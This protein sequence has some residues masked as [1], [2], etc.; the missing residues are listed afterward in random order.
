MNA[1]AQSAEG[2]SWDTLFLT[3]GLSRK[4]GGP[5]LSVSGLAK[6]VMETGQT[7]VAVVGAYRNAGDWSLDRQH[8]EPLC[9][10]ALPR[11]GIGTAGSVAA[12]IR[13]AAKNASAHGRRLVVHSSGLWDAASLAVSLSGIARK[14][15]LV[16]SP[17]GM[18]EPWALGHH[19]LRKQAAL[20]AWQRRQLKAAA[21]LHATSDL[22]FQS[23]RA[24]G[25]RNPVCVIP[26]G[27]EPPP[28]ESLAKTKLERVTRR[29]VFLSRLHPKKG[30]P[31]LL[32]AWAQVQPQ[33]WELEI[34]GEAADGYDREL[35]RQIAGL[36]LQGVRLVGEKTGNEKWQFLA[37]ADLFVLPSYSENFGIAVAESMAMGVPVIT[38]HGT[39]W[40]VLN[41]HN[42]GWW[43]PP[44]TASIVAALRQAVAEPADALAARGTRASDYAR[45][46]FGWPG[47][48]ERMVAC[49][50]WLLDAGDPPG[51]L[52]LD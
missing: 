41:Q 38:T 39:P 18:L 9:I 50:R 12:A 20:A 28:R 31:M 11:R 19:R 23:I 44:D 37:D 24:F 26:N 42:M 2:G 40:E 35:A 10:T 5:F 1:R 13:S 14:A 27:S 15:P 43:V 16:I 22:E 30:V 45:A 51:D 46:V 7:S 4:D 8:W 36:G 25:L 29:C 48:G 3:T 6:A 47:I 34:A 33:G 21:M 32:E 52:R 49:Y 17:R